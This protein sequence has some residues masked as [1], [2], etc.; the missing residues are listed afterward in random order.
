MSASADHNLLFGILALQMDFVTRDQLVA[1]MNAWVLDKAKPLGEILAAQGA[2]SPQRVALLTALM[3]EHLKQHGDDAGKS[4]AALSSVPLTLK[5][6]LAAL[7]DAALQASVGVVGSA[8]PDDADDPYATRATVGQ[9]TSG[10]LRFRIL[11]PH[12]EGGLG[13]VSVAEDG[14]L[15]REVALKEIKDKF[16]DHPESRA[17]FVVEAEITGGL[18]HP[19]IVPVYGL[20]SYAD[21]RPFYAMRFIR[22]DSLKEAIKRFHSSGSPGF[23]SLEF[24]QLLGRFVDV[25]QAIAYAHSRQVLHRDLKPGNIMLGRY[26]ETLVVDWGLAKPLIGA[27]SLSDAGEEPALTPTSLSGTGETLPG[28]AIGTPEFMSPEQAAGRLDRI[29]PATDIYSLGATLYAVLTGR[30]PVTGENVAEVL[31]KVERGEIPP[32]RAVN[33]K[34]PPALAAV[35]AKALAL[36]PDDRYGTALDL[37]AEVE[38]W[39]ADEPVMAWRE[40]WGVRSW[41]WVR[42]HRALTATAAALVVAAAAGLGLLAL[43]R[44]RARE[45]VQA[46]RDIVTVQ[47]MRTRQALDDMV[48]EDS[49]AVLGL[50]K[51]LT[52]AQRDFLKRAATYYEEFAAEAATDAEGQK[53]LG[54]AQVRF[55]HILS[56]LGR[57][58][59]AVTAYR[60]AL[61]AFARL[62]AEHP[63]MPDYRWQLASTHTSLGVVLDEQGQREQ[64]ATEY[65]QA[66]GVQEK[67]AAEFPDVAV[68]RQGLAFSQNNFGNLLAAL[69][70][71]EDAAKACR[72]AIDAYAQ[73]AT[74]HPSVPVYRHGMAGAHLNLGHLLDELGKRTEAEAEYR[75]AVE[76]DAK[77]VA[78]YPGV[79]EYRRELA[80]V[81]NNLGISLVQLGRRDEAATAFR[82]SLEVKEKLAAE[83]PGVPT[84]RRELASIQNNLGLLLSQMGRG[85]EAAAAH[86]RALDLQEKLAAEYP[87]VPEYSREI[88]RSHNNLGVLF[89][90]MGRIDDAAAAYRRALDIQEKLAA[91]HPGVPAYTIHLGN[92]YCNFGMIAHQRGDS[93][94]AVAWHTKAIE[95]LAPIVAAEPRLVEARFYL[96]NAHW[97]RA[98]DLVELQR[99]AEAL[100]DWDRALEFDDGSART[101]LRL[102]RAACLARLGRFAAAVPVAEELAVAQAAANHLYAC[103][104]VLSLSSAVRD[105]PAAAAHA[106]RA[107]RL[108]RQ[109][110]A[111]GYADIPNLLTDADLVPLRPR[112][113]YADLLW[114]LADTPAK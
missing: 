64:A 107:V 13:R 60:R 36:K 16:A 29:G 77:L 54:D 65:R 94:A 72:K 57:R 103:A 26:G 71:R 43:E 35:C 22:G 95:R 14:E 100:G 19:G 112:A 46:E 30:A 5:Q 70:Q 37:A 110:V 91:E 32:P 4:L 89:A 80:T 34:A 111:K 96:R 84:Y 78:D 41:R 81:H 48:S 62:A 56:N 76:I 68:Y 73:L 27:G 61:D 38:H 49:L 93:A 108:L 39:L 92:S 40:P 45:A 42:R 1:A 47:K 86:R 102:D 28:Q 114:D 109:A 17:R 11:R 83:F 24:R 85:D 8:R 55:A 2:L 7:P 10:G 9:S 15:H 98:A 99:S 21:G 75:Q 63:G 51:N 53:L 106:A 59:E 25:C 87:T 12:A 20:G 67:M 18:E 97:A 113:D 33:P 52:D 105:N 66:L 58:D 82:Q 74:E 50:Q 79:L 31:R 3:A 23:D 88:A 104:R 44:E 101:D 69:G 6:Q 90:G